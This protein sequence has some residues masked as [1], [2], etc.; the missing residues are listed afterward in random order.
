MT[1]GSSGSSTE[2]AQRPLADEARDYLDGVASQLSDLP[3]EE[4]TDLIEELEAHL[5]EISAEG[6]VSLVTRLGSPAA[7]AAELRASAGLPP[8]RPRGRAVARWRSSVEGW[9][10]RPTAVTVREFVGSLRPFWWVVRAWLLVAL[11]GLN[12]SP[13]WAHPIFFVPRVVTGEVGGVLLLVAVVA[14][15]QRGRRPPSGRRSTRRWVAALNV[16]AVVAVPYVFAS[17]A[18]A[19]NRQVSRLSSAALYASSD[20]QLAPTAAPAEGIYSAGQQVWNIYP[21]DAQGRLLHDVR[22]YDSAGTP[23]SLGLAFDSTKQQ[24]L[25]SQGQKV[26]NAFP[27]RYLDPTN[28]EVTDPDAGPPIVAPPLL[29]APTATPA[30]TPSPTATTPPVTPERSTSPIPKASRRTG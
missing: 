27:Y 29:G 9:L 23:L 7:Y 11:L 14:S 3:L 20:A 8:A 5:A 10:A 22:L 15:V 6:D 21:Y 17:L 16:V 30:V 28:G 1:S 25:D 24:T 18:D 2:Q 4:R 12:S 13:V 19:S 26:D